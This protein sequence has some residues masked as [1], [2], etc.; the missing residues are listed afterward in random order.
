MQLNQDIVLKLVPEFNGD[1]ENL[2]K[3]IYFMKEMGKMFTRPEDHSM[4]LLLIKSK[5]TDRAFEVQKNKK[6]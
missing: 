1:K 5:L 3:F 6:F 4:L 2:S